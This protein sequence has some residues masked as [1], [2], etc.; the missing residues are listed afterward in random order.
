M[1]Q[2]LVRSAKRHLESSV[3]EWLKRVAG[4]RVFWMEAGAGSTFGMP[5]ACLVL[6]GGRT[7]WLELKRGHVT[8]Q[9]VLTFKL[10]P[11]QK[12][13][14]K[15]LGALGARVGV[16]VRVAAVD[17]ERWL[18]GRGA[19]TVVLGLQ[20]GVWEGRVN[21]LGEL[22]LTALVLRGAGSPADLRSLCEC[23]GLGDSLRG[24]S[25]KAQGR[26]LAEKE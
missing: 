11:E 5:D 7:L 25:A 12:R 21:L 20:P 8:D 1:Q 3:R 10:R 24:C 15:R 18:I 17:E 14:L 16:L 23:L 9:G 4:H 22:G 26:G 6:E 19:C 2:R 13:T